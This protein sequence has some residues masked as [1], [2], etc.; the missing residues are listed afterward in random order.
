VEVILLKDFDLGDR[1]TV[2]KVADGYA[3][4]YLLPNNLAV[5]ASAGNKN[6]VV[7][8]ALQQ[9]RKLEKEKSAVELF[10]KQINEHAEISIKV[11]GSEAG[12][13]YGA[14]TN[15]QLADILKQAHNTEFDKKRIMVKQL[16]E[17]GAYEVPVRLTFGITA[18]AKIKIELELDKSMVESKV[19][20]VKKTA[21]K[22]EEATEEVV[23]PVEADTKPKK[24][25]K[26]KVAKEA[27][28]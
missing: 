19:K 6:H 8:I 22:T 1:G 28:A 14:V 12:V 24:A 5:E 15:A 7:Q 21:K 17:P 18:K 27:K 20:K 3:R 23:T 2:I 4:N 10:A 13:L 26:E 9:Q 11:K 25:K 16:R